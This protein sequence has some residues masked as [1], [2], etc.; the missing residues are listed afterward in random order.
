MKYRKNGN[1]KS[2]LEILRI[3]CCICAALGWW[4]ALYPELTMTYDTYCI[5]DEKGCRQSEEKDGALDR[6]AQVYWDILEAG[7]EQIQYR[8]KLL[9][10]I[11]K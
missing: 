7:P 3:F 5:V 2:R 10:W 8:S 1:K 11:K 4:G 6:G 9:E